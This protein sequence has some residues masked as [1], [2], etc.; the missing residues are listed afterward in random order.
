VYPFIVCLSETAARASYDYVPLTQ[1][2]C[3]LHRLRD[4]HL[5]I[6]VMRLIH[7]LGLWGSAA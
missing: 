2:K 5:L 4:G 7:A 1:V 6:A 3:N